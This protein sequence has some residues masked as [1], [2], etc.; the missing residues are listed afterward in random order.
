MCFNKIIVFQVIFA[1]LFFPFLFA[2]K[3]VGE[4]DSYLPYSHG[5]AVCKA[6]NRIFCAASQSVFS[7]NLEDN[8]FEKFNKVNGL[9]DIGISTIAYDEALD[10]LLIAYSNTNIDILRNNRIINI[11]DIK[12]KIIQGNK[13]INDIKFIG[14]YAYLACGFG[15]VVVN[16]D[17]EEIA[18]TYYIAENARRINVSAIEFDGENIYAAT[19]EGIFF[20]DIESQN[21]QDYR[22][23]NRLMNL[24]DPN[25]N[26]TEM[27]IFNGQIFVSYQFGEEDSDEIY[28][29]FSDT[30]DKLPLDAFNV[31]N[32]QSSDNH[33]VITGFKHLFVLDEERNI[34]TGYMEYN[35]GWIEPQDAMITPGGTV[36]IAD[37]LSGLVKKHDPHT[38]I[39]ENYY[40]EGPRHS[41]SEDMKFFNDM[42]WV[43]A[44]SR[45]PPFKWAGRGA[46]SYN[47]ESWTNYNS[48][49]FPKLKGIKN[50]SSIAIDPFDE[51][52]AFG[53][54]FGY[55]I[56]EFLNGEI[57][58]VFGPDNSVLKT[59]SDYGEGYIQIEDLAFDFNQNLWII[60]SQ[61]PDPVYVKPPEGEIREFELDRSFGFD[62][63]L[64]KILITQY[65]HIWTIHNKK[66]NFGF[67]VFDEQG[68]EKR[69][70]LLN[71]D[72][73]KEQRRINCFVEDKDG[74][75]WIGTDEGIYIYYN[76]ES[77]FGN[78][79]PIGQRIIVTVDGVNQYLLSTEYIT[80]IIVDDGNRKWIGTEN[81]GV[82]LLSPDGTKQIHHFTEDN[83]PLY[84]DNISSIAINRSSGEVFFGTDQGILSYKEAA[85]ESYQTFDDVYV[86]PNP[87]RETYEGDVYIKGLLPETIVKITD[88]SGNIVYETTSLGGQA[89]WSGKNFDGHRVRTG[90]YLVFLS[91]QDGTESFVT[92]L[93]FIN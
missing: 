9:S 49:N 36:W 64:R 71:A 61:V 74:Q 45:N 26:Y 86:Y 14:N 12:R 53:G 89:V 21:L 5:K 73:N 29:I 72:G 62:D 17:K 58:E 40:P 60:S 82:F 19:E 52:H 25:G 3:S 33:F 8:S 83:S 50:I 7:L 63:H 70:D 44:G 59:I 35:W 46:Y 18:N 43:A 88:I 79:T 68:N 32:M 11:S 2:Q 56:I 22:N 84:S 41:S 48:V 92:K 38:Q 66:E 77:V 67:F 65:G 15:I 39:F 42:L 31:Y 1:F 93:L 4:W 23:W 16:I 80:S 91:N 47:F 55:G 85:I 51:N 87:I 27:N 75:I 6:G 81:S 54:S 13:T 76:P 10:V 57:K 20:A 34:E 28:V 69:F 37:D 78:Y 30:Y 24:P 90:V